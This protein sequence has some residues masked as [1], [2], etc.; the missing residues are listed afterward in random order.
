MVGKIILNIFLTIVAIIAE[1]AVWGFIV[2]MDYEDGL[3]SQ[4]LL[5]IEKVGCFSIFPVI[6]FIV[7]LWGKFTIFLVISIILWGIGL[8]IIS[9]W[10]ICKKSIEEKFW[11]DSINLEMIKNMPSDELKSA[12]YYLSED[13]DLVKNISQ[14]VKSNGDG[15]IKN[16]TKREMIHIRRYTKGKLLEINGD[17]IKIQFDVNEDCSLAFKYK[18]EYDYEGYVDDGSGRFFLLMQ[19]YCTVIYN[20]DEYHCQ[21]TDG[22]DFDDYNIPY[23]KFLLVKH[24]K[25]KTKKNT[26]KGA[27]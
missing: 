5:P 15:K 1:G 4:I 10:F 19:D 21:E 26:A 18:P 8:L 16:D 12:I 11:H 3:L 25:I 27:W 2:Y 23:L 13:L 22:S 6:V 14:S 17:L 20:K 24:N 7:S 9:C